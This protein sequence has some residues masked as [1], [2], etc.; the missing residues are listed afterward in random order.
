M[1]WF[2]SLFFD[3]EP[4][5]GKLWEYNGHMEKWLFL[6]QRYTKFLR[7]NAKSKK[8]VLSHGKTIRDK[9]DFKN[10]SKNMI[11]HQI[12]NK[13]LHYQ[14]AN[15][16][17]QCPRKRNSKLILF[18][19][20]CGLLHSARRST[21]FDCISSWIFPPT[22]CLVQSLKSHFLNRKLYSK[23]IVKF[24]FLVHNIL[25]LENGKLF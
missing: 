10:M 3:E 22:L 12:E 19:I 9:K 23:R 6:I 21:N 20:N 5:D 25:M 24:K 18:N 11:K 17:F 8:V 1:F 7:L 16:H 15:S 4:F 2:H 13:Y 14:I